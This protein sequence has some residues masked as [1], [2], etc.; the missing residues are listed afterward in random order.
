MENVIPEAVRKEVVNILTPERFKGN[1]DIRAFVK[2]TRELLEKIDPCYVKYVDKIASQSEYFRKCA[3]QVNSKL[4]AVLVEIEEVLD[5]QA[6]INKFESVFK[7]MIKTLKIA[8][9][10]TYLDCVFIGDGESRF[11]GNGDIYV[12]GANSGKLPSQSGGGVVLTD[13]DE[14]MLSA[15][16]VEITPCERQKA[17][18]GMYAVCDLMK[19]RRADSW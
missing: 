4:E 17:L 9:V 5:E 8:L 3:E 18:D 16:G 7:S 11:A 10:P 15:L 19:N 6:D 2:L 13:K 12:L 14:Q 1:K